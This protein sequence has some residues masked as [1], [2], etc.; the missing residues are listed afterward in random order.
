MIE[1]DLRKRVE[2]EKFQKLVKSL[3]MSIVAQVT[4]VL[5]MGGYLVDKMSTSMFVVWSAAFSV[6]CIGCLIIGLVYRYDERHGRAEARFEQYMLI[7]MICSFLLGCFWTATAFSRLHEPLSEQVI[8]LLILVGQTAGSV[9][10][11]APNMKL[12]YSGVPVSLLPLGIGFLWLGD[13]AHSILGALLILFFLFVSFLAHMVNRLVTESIWLRFQ[14]DDLLA[15]KSQFLASA[16]HDLRQPLH[17]LTLYISALEQRETS[18]GSRDIMGKVRTTLASLQRLFDGLLD[19]S[20]FDAGVCQPDMTDVLWSDV[21]EKLREEFS[22]LAAQKHIAIQWSAL[23]VCFRSDALLLEQV[24]RN[25]VGNAIRYTEKGSIS[26]NCV[27]DASAAVEGEPWVRID[28]MDTGIGIDKQHQAAIF[29]P[30]YRA[31]NGA[32]CQ[33]LPGKMSTG[34]GLSIAKRLTEVLGHELSLVSEKGRGSCFSLRL[35]PGDRGQVVLAQE[36]VGQLSQHLQEEKTAILVIDSDGAMR[37][38][39]TQLLLS[40]GCSVFAATTMEAAYRHVERTGYRPDGVVAEAEFVPA[41]LDMAIRFPQEQTPT[42]IIGGA[43]IADIEVK[44]DFQWLRKPLKPAGLRAFVI[45]CRN[46]GMKN[47]KIA[48]SDTVPMQNA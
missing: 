1:K 33:G 37:D 22:A 48:R 7:A 45:N 21:R 47:N 27:L 29:D 36:A 38:A 25:L 20:K 17:A 44:G 14:N 28:V 18:S 19:M 35:M 40:W 9:M 5:L 4:V 26:I 12:F 2:R 6:L 23:E 30:Y 42:L 31:P 15:E 39:T 46:N 32:E 43:D 13:Q 10:A 16:S 41:L 24:L 8:I 3:H 11:L 34:L